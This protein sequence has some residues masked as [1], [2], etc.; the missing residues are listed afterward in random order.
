MCA[1]CCP[2]CA[3]LDLSNRQGPLRD[4]ATDST[5]TVAP[6]GRGRPF[7]PNEFALDNVDGQDDDCEK[8]TETG[9]SSTG[10]DYDE[11]D[12]LNLA[13]YD[14]L[15][16]SGPASLEV[17]REALCDHPGL[18]LGVRTWLDTGVIVFDAGRLR[19]CC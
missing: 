7:S 14:F 13:I 2:E 18:E 17:L 19:L 16:E 1:K 3:P 12:R 5:Y 15:V 8:Y 10:S 6:V 9:H 11:R 4:T